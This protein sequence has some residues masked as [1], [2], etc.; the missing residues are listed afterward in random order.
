MVSRVFVPGGGIDEDPVTGSAHCVLAPYWATRLGRDHFAAWQASTRG[1]HIG[2]RLIDDQVDALDG[3]MGRVADAGGIQFRM[4]NTQ[5]PR[6]GRV[7]ELEE[8]AFTYQRIEW[9]WMEGNISADDD[10]EI[11]RV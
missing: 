11:A 9:T 6:H 3:L 4:L 5:H 8:I 7:P 2:C 10:W 1:G